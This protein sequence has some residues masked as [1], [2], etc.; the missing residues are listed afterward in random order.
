[1]NYANYFSVVT[2]DNGQPNLSADQFR[3]MMNIVFIEGVIQ[4]IKRIKEKETGQYFKYD[5]LIFKHDSVLTELTGNLKPNEL[6][7]EM[8]RLSRS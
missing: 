5:V 7:K 8:Y 3:R 6:L 4:G 1:M 2:K